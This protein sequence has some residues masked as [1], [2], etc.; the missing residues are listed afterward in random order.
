LPVGGIKEKSGCK[1]CGFKRNLMCAA[2][3]KDVKEIDGNFIKGINFI[4]KNS[5]NWILV[6]M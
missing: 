4:I 1:A 3:E 2:N 6:L 5:R